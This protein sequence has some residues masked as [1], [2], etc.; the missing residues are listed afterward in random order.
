MVDRGYDEEMAGQ[1][2]G[3]LIRL[4]NRL[5]VRDVSL[6]AEFIDANELGRALEQMAYALGEDDR[7]LTSQ[8][9]VDMLAL[10]ERMRMGTR[11]A[12]DFDPALGLRRSASPTV[13]FRACVLSPPAGSTFRCNRS[14]ELTPR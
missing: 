1:L 8:E 11:V 14:G 4:E 3:L 10:A 12:E 5:P 6:A 2:R 7:P 9:R 13:A